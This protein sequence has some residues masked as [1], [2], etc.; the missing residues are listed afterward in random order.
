MKV[1]IIIPVY[2]VQD[3]ILKCLK[4]VAGQTFQQDVEC[5]IIDDCGQDNSISLAADFISKYSGKILFKII[6]RESNGG[7]SAAR[8]TGLDNA[9][10]DYLYF[11]DSDDWIE[12]NTIQRIVE[13]MNK[14]VSMYT[15]GFRKETICQ[16]EIYLLTPLKRVSN[17]EGGKER[18]LYLIDDFYNFNSGYSVWSRAYRRDIIEKHHIRFEDNKKIWAEDVYFNTCYI[19]VSDSIMSDD[20]MLYHYVQREGSLMNKDAR[21]NNLGRFAKLSKAIYAFVCS[22]CQEIE[23]YFPIINFS[24]MGIEGISNSPT[25]KFEK[26]ALMQ[27]SLDEKQYYTY[28]LNKNFCNYRN[29][30][31]FPL[32]KW[33]IVN[34]LSAWWLQKDSSELFLNK[35]MLKFLLYFRKELYLQN[36]K[37]MSSYT[38][39]V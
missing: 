39:N 34:I 16:R 21:K 20:C 17:I 5:L 1:S 32:Y 25:G 27:L 23:H 6:K 37:F 28:W 19:L 31:L 8:N 14:G 36:D 9:I 11:L 18:I 38:I 22:E 3:Y 13:N 33:C 12:P 7:L 24:L 26:N 29:L 2:N 30:T 15:F 10:G 35:V 4:S